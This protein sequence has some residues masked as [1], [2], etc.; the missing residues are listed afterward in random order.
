MWRRTAYTMPLQTALFYY[1]TANHLRPYR[2]DKLRLLMTGAVTWAEY[3]HAVEI[4]FTIRGG[5]GAD[6]ETLRQ[7]ILMVLWHQNFSK[8]R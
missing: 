1:V 4:E 8:Q 2:S 7:I 3:L 5:Y 6:L